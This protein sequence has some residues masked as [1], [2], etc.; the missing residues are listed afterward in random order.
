M[1][2]QLYLLSPQI[3]V[4]VKRKQKEN[5]ENRKR[6]NATSKKGDTAKRKMT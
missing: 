6:K 4:T 2:S 1:H 3:K 5:T